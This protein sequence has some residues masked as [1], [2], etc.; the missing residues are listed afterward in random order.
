[1]MAMVPAMTTTQML[2]KIQAPVPVGMGGDM[3]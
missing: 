3:P 1:M 2:M